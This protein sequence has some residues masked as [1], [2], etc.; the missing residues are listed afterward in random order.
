M[1]RSVLRREGKEIKE[2]S[3]NCGGMSKP[4]LEKG[5]TGTEPKPIPENARKEIILVHILVIFVVIFFIMA[6]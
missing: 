3:D 4:I 1:S 6:L 5:R 2:N